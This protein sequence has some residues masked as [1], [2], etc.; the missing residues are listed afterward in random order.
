M[1]Q[2]LR[3]AIIERDKDT[4]G[5]GK[6]KEIV[7]L[8]QKGESGQKVDKFLKDI[9]PKWYAFLKGTQEFG[10]KVERAFL[11]STSCTKSSIEICETSLSTR[12]AMMVS[13]AARLMRK[14]MREL[15]T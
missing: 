8:H 12:G 9:E 15:H 10:G 14:R 11:K 5:Y 2:W 1:K 6:F 4:V 7:D 3:A 13:S